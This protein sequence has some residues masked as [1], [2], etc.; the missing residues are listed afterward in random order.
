MVWIGHV[1]SDKFRRDFVT[2]TLA[3]IAPVQPIFQRVSCSNEMVPNVPKHYE[4]QQ[5]MSLG[6]NAVDRMCSLPK[7]P[8]RLCGTNI[9]TN[10]TSSACFAPSFTFVI[11]QSQMHLN[12]MKHAK[13]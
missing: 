11:K 10:C 7:I 6:S 12:T 13:I 3:L 1:R 5:N 4:M 8:T 9:C 2:Q